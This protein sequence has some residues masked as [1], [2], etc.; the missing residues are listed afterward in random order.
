MLISLLFIILMIVAGVL[1]IPINAR[2]TA[3]TTLQNGVIRLEVGW[4]FGAWKIRH[5]FYIRLLQTPV[6]TLL[7]E[8]RQGE[9]RKVWDLSHTLLPKDRSGRWSKLL[10]KSVGRHLRLKKFHIRGHVG[11]ED[12]AYLTALLSGAV[13]MTVYGYFLYRFNQWQRPKVQVDVLPAFYKTC[14]RLNLEGIAHC[15]PLQI[16]SAVILRRIQSKKGELSHV[17][18]C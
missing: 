14:F 1:C 4:L 7:W 2:L 16:I 11:I 3:Y 18:S 12:D 8:N 9:M 15:I 6:L 13:G 17:T 5:R 10:L